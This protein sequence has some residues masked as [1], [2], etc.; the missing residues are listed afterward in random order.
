VEYP[1]KLDVSSASIKC[2][3]EV[4]NASVGKDHS[5]S[6]IL[7]IIRSIGFHSE[8]QAT[9]P[10][11]LSFLHI[12]VQSI[13]KKINQLEVILNDFP[14]H[15]LCVNEHWLSAQEMDLYV[16]TNY[17]LANYLCRSDSPHG[18]VAIYLRQNLKFEFS[19]LDVSS[20]SEPS[21]FEIVGIRVPCFKL[22]IFSLYCLP[23]ID[24][25]VLHAKFDDLYKS[26]NKYPHYDFIILG[27]LNINTLQCTK[28]SVHNFFN[29]LTSYHWSIY[30]NLPT[31]LEACLDNVIT[32]ANFDDIYCGIVSLH[33]SD[34]LGVWVVLRTKT[35]SNVS[36]SST[37]ST[38]LSTCAKVRNLNI[39]CIMNLR[40]HLQKINFNNLLTTLFDIDLV[41]NQFINILSDTIQITCPLRSTKRIQS[42]TRN[43]C[44]WYNPH[45]DKLKTSLFYW[46]VQLKMGNPIAS[47]NYSKLKKD[48]RKTLSMAKRDYYDNIIAAASNKSVA[49]WSL[50]RKSAKCNKVNDNSKISPDEFNNFF[51]QV[52]PST[53]SKF[54]PANFKFF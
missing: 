41:W 9:Q 43:I 14:V 31:R 42:K 24:F 29:L 21:V 47:L 44:P 34:H 23:K 32:K 1:G 18:G 11:G 7:R 8:L 33:I 12:N 26:I 38:G 37:L 10:H 5:A 16:P 13:R 40:N 49:A 25:K 50:I 22:L 6:Q 2:P 17:Y 15:I 4:S 27:D 35:P 30:N 51:V 52:A 19:I 46:H 28:L 3:I 36:E 54:E 45:L 20:F 48:Y 39:K 53:F